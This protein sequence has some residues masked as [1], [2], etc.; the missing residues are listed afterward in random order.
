M[1]LPFIL[2]FM[3]LIFLFFTAIS[4]FFFLSSFFQ[5]TLLLV[6]FNFLIL[7][8][9]CIVRLVICELLIGIKKRFPAYYHYAFSLSLLLLFSFFVIISEIIL[10][11]HFLEPADSAVVSCTV[12]II[13][14]A[15]NILVFGVSAAAIVEAMVPP[16]AKKSDV[17]HFE[18]I[19]INSDEIFIISLN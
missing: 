18:N 16:E 11:N 15:F 4:L 12:S 2:R 3:L 7:A 5:P 10:R 9:D 17:K 6:V 14:A 19:K 13:Y 8:Q 1:Q